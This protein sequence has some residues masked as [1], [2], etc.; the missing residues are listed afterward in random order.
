MEIQY[1]NGT[2]LAKAKSDGRI[3]PSLERFFIKSN[4]WKWDTR[5][6]A[7]RA[8]AH[9]LYSFLA[10][11][12]S[13][14][15]SCTE[16]ITLNHNPLKI[17]TPPLELRPYQLEACRQWNLHGRR[18]VVV[19]PTGAGKTRLA[20]HCISS[21]QAKTLILV[22]TRVLL[23]QWAEE[24]TSRLKVPAGILG[25]SQWRLADITVATF[26]SA[27]RS[28]GNIGEQFKLVIVDEAHHFLG[29]ER[30]EII[31][32]LC[33]P[34]CL[35]L[36]ATFSYRQNGNIHHSKIH[37]LLGPIVFQM[38]LG[39]LKGTV[40]APFQKFLIPVSLTIVERRLYDSLMRSFRETFE[41]LKSDNMGLNSN[42]LFQLLGRSLKG[43]RALAN[44]REARQI[45][46]QCDEK[47]DRLGE[48][49]LRFR[50]RKI[51]IFT[52]DTCTALKVSSELLVFPIL[53]Q[54]PKTERTLGIELFRNSKIGSLVTCRV[55]NEGFD[56]PSAD[57]AI[58]LGGAHGE[59]EHIQRI[60][61]VLRS[62][63]GKSA[64]IYELVCR[65]SI[66]T[67]QWKKRNNYE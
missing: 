1:D 7:Y 49:L 59:R 66:E 56:I 18:G 11:I 67:R 40:L 64:L 9:K 8:P 46:S 17:K 16:K 31:E 43:K 5:V 20:L 62:A 4:Y 32:M 28:A 36:S 38:S 2:I 15:F 55:L 53:S 34:Y 23:H 12:K 41:T 60:G 19:L 39:D 50:D 22:P 54:T 61:R 30:V 13:L 26:E 33:A 65:E 47:I 14:N 25:D 3:S 27:T 52:G 48:L 37:T 58:I 10:E 29:G 51:L 63:P 57:M 45:V 6:A 35:S 24:I 42:E 44:L 21:V